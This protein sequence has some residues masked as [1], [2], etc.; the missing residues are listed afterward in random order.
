MTHRRWRIEPPAMGDTMS[1]MH[2]PC[3]V[4]A[5]AAA[6]TAIAGLGSGALIGGM[7]TSATSAGAQTP[8]PQHYLCYQA[9]AKKGF[10][11]PKGI[12][13]INSLVPNGFVPTV[14]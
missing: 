13:L 4:R 3:G 6:A 5:L 12:R 14:G 8:A 10:T 1:R 2:R 7:T 11:V 9:S